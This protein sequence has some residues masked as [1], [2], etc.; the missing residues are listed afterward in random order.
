MCK[1]GDKSGIISGR[2]WKPCTKAKQISSR[3]RHRLHRNRIPNT[4]KVNRQARSA[5]QKSRNKRIWM[6]KNDAVIYR[7]SNK[8]KSI[9]R[10]NLILLE[11]DETQ[12]YC[13][14]KRV[15]AR[16][17]LIRQKTEMQ[18]TTACYV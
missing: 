1:V 5:K 14:V 11:S 12:H 9:P 4:N 7:I 8:E 10:I 3:R 17:Y 6:G 13:C 15:S 18:S 2:A 16:C